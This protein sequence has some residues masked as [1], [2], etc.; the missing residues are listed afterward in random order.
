LI[1]DR[2]RYLAYLRDYS[3]KRRETRM[4]EAL[5]FLGAKC[6]RCGSSE[7]LEFDHIDPQSKLSNVTTL[8]HGRADK[9]W[10]EVRK[11]QLLCTDCH[12]DKSILELGNK[13]AEHGSSS[14]YR[15][16]CR[17]RACSLANSAVVRKWRSKKK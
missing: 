4:N 2:E 12:N 16:G 8:L 13:K 10:A 15:K 6:T 14:M 1:A 9:F 3:R 7:K 17:C 5:N 11:C